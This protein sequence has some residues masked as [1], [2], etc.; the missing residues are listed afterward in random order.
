MSSCAAFPLGADADTAGNTLGCR[1]YHAGAAAS[2]PTVH[3]PHAGPSGGA[4]C[5]SYCEAY[6]NLTKTACS[7][8]NALPF[9]DYSTCFSICNN[10]YNQTGAVLP[11]ATDGATVQCKIYHATVASSSAANAV[12]HCPHTSSS[13]G[14]VCGTQCEN[15]C[16]TAFRDGCTGQNN[17][18]D[19]NQCMAFCAEFPKGTFADTSGNTVECRTYHWGVASTSAANALTHCTH[20]TPSGGGGVCGSYCEVYCQLAN[21]SCTGTLALYQ[22]TSD[23]TTACNKIA[24]TGNPGDTSGDS[25]QCRIYHLGVAGQSAALATVHCPHGLTVSSQCAS[26]SSTTSSSSS[27]TGSAATIVLSVLGLLVVLFF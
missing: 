2:A 7:G 12:T 13:G 21:S 19:V 23:C 14:G 18:T 10:T 27:S 4:T 26:A 25:I 20:G 15:Y 5:G 3:C 16:Y 11:L 9:A 8:T 6:C 17:Y 22:T 24:T 1:I